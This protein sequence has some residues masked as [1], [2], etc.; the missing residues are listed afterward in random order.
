MLKIKRS[1][2]VIHVKTM[3]WLLVILTAVGCAPVVKDPVDIVLHAKNSDFVSYNVEQAE[4]SE[5]ELSTEDNLERIIELL[6]ETTGNYETV[7]DSN[8]ER[9]KNGGYTIYGELLDIFE[10]YQVIKEKEQNEAFDSAEVQAIND[11]LLD[12]LG[13]I[14]TD[15]KADVLDALYDFIDDNIGNIL[16]ELI[17]KLENEAIESPKPT[18]P[19]WDV[20]G[21]TNQHVSDAISA[22]YDI[23]KGDNRPIPSE[24][25]SR[26]RRIEHDAAK[27]A[28]LMDVKVNVKTDDFTSQ[29]Y[30]LKVLYEKHGGVC[31]LIRGYSNNP[32]YVISKCPL[33][34]P[35]SVVR[36]LCESAA[37]LPIQ[38][39]SNNA[40]DIT[41]TPVQDVEEMHELFA[42]VLK[43]KDLSK[44]G[45]LFS[46]D[47]NDIKSDLSS[48]LE[49]ICEIAK[50]SEYATS[51]KAK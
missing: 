10:N 1:I 7:E 6:K 24:D 27:E 43:K 25:D 21:W 4:N 45:E 32:I 23:I 47:D 22:H 3:Y 49:R 5:S 20:K 29:N 34:T 12:I 50:S 42:Q 39:D 19:S 11:E 2:S 44:A 14:T 40:I 35:H 26:N 16:Q 17:T 15:S 36:E 48:V 9:Q 46:I 28:P 18:K 8:H 13:E 30:N 38:I 31:T 37:P 41:K 33:G 51:L